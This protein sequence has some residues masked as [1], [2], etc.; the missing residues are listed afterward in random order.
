MFDDKETWRAPHPCNVSISSRSKLCFYFLPR[1]FSEGIDNLED[2]RTSS[3][4]KIECVEAEFIE[5]LES[6]KM[7]FCEINNMDVVSHAYECSDPAVLKSLTCSVDSVVVIAEHIEMR[8]SA[9]RNL[10]NVWH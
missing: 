5:D 2:R 4:S 3:G 1:F 6:S 8:S 7:P 10:G 9:N